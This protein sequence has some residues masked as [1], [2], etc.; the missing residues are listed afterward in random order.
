MTDIGIEGDYG[1]CDKGHTYRDVKELQD[2]TDETMVGRRR[3]KE[4]NCA[5]LAN[6]YVE[7]CGIF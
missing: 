3:F 7:C 5:N 1:D 6:N 2:K 4:G